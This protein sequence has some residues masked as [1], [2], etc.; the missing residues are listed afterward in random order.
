MKAVSSLSKFSCTLEKTSV[1]IGNCWS[2]SLMSST[3][4]V[5]GR[6]VW[7]WMKVSGS[8]GDP[9]NLLASATSLWS[10]SEF[11]N[12]SSFVVK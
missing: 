2:C 9:L 10:E 8:N 12:L 11:R 4:S 7:W 1:L 5:E 3:R 6:M